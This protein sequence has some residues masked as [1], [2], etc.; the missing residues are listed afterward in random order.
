MKVEADATSYSP[1]TPESHKNVVVLPLSHSAPQ[2][3]QGI[4]KIT[5]D[6]HP[7]ELHG[8]IESLPLIALKEIQ[9]ECGAA[10]TRMGKGTMG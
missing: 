5:K 9:V 7:G 2:M 8:L 6:L 3:P 1:P 4:H 10:W